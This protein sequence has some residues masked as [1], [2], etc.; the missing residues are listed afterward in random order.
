MAPT[1]LVAPIFDRAAEVNAKLVLV[2]DP[3][4]LP[5]IG[6]GGLLSGLAARL[7]PIELTENRRQRTN[8]ER[9]ALEQLRSGDV[10]K[11]LNAY[12]SNGRIHALATAAE[13]KTRMVDDWLAARANGADAIMLASRNVDIADLNDLAH[14]HLV[15]AGVVHGPIRT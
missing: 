5:E 13:T 11:A 3:R 2:G 12:L 15:D 8:W 14:R 9:T 10:G 1:R 6:A 7:V 4:Q